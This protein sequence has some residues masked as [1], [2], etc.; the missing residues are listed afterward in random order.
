LFFGRKSILSS[1]VM[2]QSILYPPIFT[3]IIH[4]S[5]R[6]LFDWDSHNIDY[7]Q[8]IAAYGHLYSFTSVKAVVHWFQIMRNS[9]FQMYDD[10]VI[11][12]ITASSSPGY[13]PVRFP[14]KNITTPIV[15]IWGDEDSLVD[16]ETMRR[17]L[18]EHTREVKLT[19]YEHLD[20]LWGK[21]IDKDVIPIVLEALEEFVGRVSPVSPTSEA[22]SP[23]HKITITCDEY[24]RE[25]IHVK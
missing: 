7:W 10:S 1:V 6:F 4:N 9:A 17:Q 25:L 5:L 8:R 19:G 16:I 23:Q 11:S 20:L 12:P 18:P 21:D 13:R 14:T 2:W 22:T 24:P 3:S 15:L